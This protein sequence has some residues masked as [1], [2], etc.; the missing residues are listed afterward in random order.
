MDENEN[1]TKR[2]QVADLLAFIDQ[3]IAYPDATRKLESLSRDLSLL[4]D[5]QL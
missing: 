5:S 2:R 4:F 1:P 3:I